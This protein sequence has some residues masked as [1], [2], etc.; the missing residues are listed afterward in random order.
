MVAMDAHGPHGFVF[1]EALSLQVM[2]KDQAE[3]DRYWE[4]LSEG[5]TQSVCG[6]LKDRFGLSWQV[7]PE[8]IAAWMASNDTAARDRA[9]AAMMTMKKLDI[10][11][12]DRALRG[13]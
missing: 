8:S 3:L 9:F 12:L 13:A 7:V 5:G 4:T 2:C 11:T 1:N 10:A 6:W